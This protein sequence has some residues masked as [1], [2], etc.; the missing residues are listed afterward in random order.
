[1]SLALLQCWLLLS[2]PNS[3]ARDSRAAVQ[4]SWAS[5]T[6]AQVSYFRC[7]LQAL[8]I[9]FK[10]ANGS[11]LSYIKGWILICEPSW[12]L[13]FLGAMEITKPR[14]KCVKGRNEVILTEREARDGK[15]YSED[16]VQIQ[17]FQTWTAPNSDFPLQ[18]S[19]QT[20]A[21]S[22]KQM[23][24]TFF[25][26]RFGFKRKVLK[27]PSAGTSLLPCPQT[28]GCIHSMPQW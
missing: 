21:A 8:V 11:S 14:R 10:V 5:L 25:S 15:N 12:Q 27:Q 19:K 16:T 18:L 3:P 2:L 7:Q 20:S 22:L 23:L 9:I 24:S 4:L 26:H 28:C 1:M 17:T 13:H 6:P